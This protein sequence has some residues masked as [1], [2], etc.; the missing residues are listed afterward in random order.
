LRSLQV[1]NLPSN[2][3]RLARAAVVLLSAG[4]LAAC[5]G[6][7][8]G[9]TPPNNNYGYCDPDA[10]NITT[11]RP[12][13]GFPTNNGNVEIVSSSGNDSLHSGYQFF[14]LNL[15]DNFGN[16]FATGPLSIV[17]DNGGPHPFN[18]DFYYSGTVSGGLPTNDTFAV[19]LND[20]NTNCT[21]QFV[22]NIQT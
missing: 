17:Q 7:S 8:T 2:T 20:P 6:G 19:Y 14:D 22:G 12:T 18:S 11:A 9:S 21:P 16:R 13:P 4:L 10:Q 1:R 5:G 15:V 3:P